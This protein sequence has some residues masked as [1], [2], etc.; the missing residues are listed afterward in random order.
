MAKL[1]IQNIIFLSQEHLQS[2]PITFRPYQPQALCSV[3][4]M[5]QLS[6]QEM[7]NKLL[8][9]RTV[10]LLHLDQRVHEMQPLQRN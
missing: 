10:D 3:N 2:V 6:I 9:K 5:V 7:E 4:G 8:L 1:G